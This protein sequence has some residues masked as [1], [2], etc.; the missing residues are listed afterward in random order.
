MIGK[1]RVRQQKKKRPHCCNV[2]AFLE[3]LTEIITKNFRTDKYCYLAGNFNFIDMLSMN[4]PKNSLIVC[5]LICLIASS[6]EA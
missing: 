3:K 4:P 1:R 2:A 6:N 5:F